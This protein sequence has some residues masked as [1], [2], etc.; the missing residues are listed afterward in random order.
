M[1]RRQVFGAVAA[2]AAAGMFSASYATAEDRRA[3][4]ETPKA[5]KKT[6]KCMSGNACKGKSECGVAG[7]HT[8]HAWYACRGRCATFL[9]HGLGLRREHYA[10]ILAGEP[11]GDRLEA[12]SESCRTR[13]SPSRTWRL[14]SAGCR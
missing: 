7:A 9:G 13:R 5:E 8:C 11:A 2:V 14:L 3:A 4:G 1:N 12:I 6:V 10:A